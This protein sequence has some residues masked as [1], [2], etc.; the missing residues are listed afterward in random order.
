[1]SRRAVYCASACAVLA[2]TAVVSPASH[3]PNALWQIVHDMCVPHQERDH[4]SLPCTEVDL[5][6]GFAIL[7]DIRGKTRYLL[8]P[9]TRITGIE[10][11]AILEPDAPNFW[12]DAWRARDYV[13]ARAGRN[14]PRDDIAL[15]INAVTGRT[16]N[17]LHIHI[18]C[19]R[20]DVRDTLRAHAT[21]IGPHWAPFPVRL[22]DHFYQ[23][24][25]VQ[26]PELD[27]VNP[28]ALL[29]ASVP[30]ASAEMGLETLVVTGADAAVAQP[31][32]ILLA[33][34]ADR[35]RGDDGSGE[36]LEDHSC[37]VARV[38]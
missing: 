20:R 22:S 30:R 23:A 12:A 11:P 34:R 10:D 32:F 28:F 29:A 19:V 37:M 9:T 36:E 6:G 31:G 4:S 5:H 18:D 14:L 16:Q 25:R 35:A 21:D 13:E 27:E 3:D 7:K 17:Q 26:S 24:V 2:M 15:A 38:P 33:D 8:I 1:M